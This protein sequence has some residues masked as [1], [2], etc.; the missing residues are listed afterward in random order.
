MATSL[1][2]TVHDLLFLRVTGIRID[3]EDLDTVPVKAELP[4]LNPHEHDPHE[5]AALE[6]LAGGAELERYLRK[7]AE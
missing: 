6:A 4:L 3:A 5:H 7:A 1:S 2:L